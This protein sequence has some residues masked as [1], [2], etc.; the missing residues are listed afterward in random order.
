VKEPKVIKFSRARLE[1]VRNATSLIGQLDA[2][3]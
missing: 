2:S 3:I 1:T